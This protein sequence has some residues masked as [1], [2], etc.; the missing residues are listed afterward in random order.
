ML[1]DYDRQN[2]SLDLQRAATAFYLHPQGKTW[3]IFL[4]HALKILQR[5]KRLERFA[6]KLGKIKKQAV[7]AERNQAINL[8]DEMLTLGVLLKKLD[9][10]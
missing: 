7:Q 6:R 2:C 4:N 10:V 8:A 5:E 3:Q 1:D 9:L